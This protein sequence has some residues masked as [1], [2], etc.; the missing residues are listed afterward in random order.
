MLKRSSSVLFG[1]AVAMTAMFAGACP[2][3]AEVALEL[4]FPE[5]S[6]VTVQVEVAVDQTLTLAGQD[7]VTKQSNFAVATSNI[8][9]RAAD[10]S[11]AVV[12][13]V[14]V[15]QSELNINGTKIQF[16]SANP[17]KKADI[18]QLEPLLDIYRAVLKFPVT[19]TLDAKNQLVS[20][21]LP[22]G[23][24][25]KLGD[26]AKEKFEPESLKKESKQ[27]YAFLPDGPVKEGDTWERSA[28][29]NLGSGQVMTFRTKYEYKGTVEHDGV[30]LDKIEGKAFEVS[31]AINGNPMLQLT[32]SDLKIKESAVT[33][34]FDRERGSV[35]SRN[36]KV[37]IDGA[38]T[39]TI[40]GMELPGKVDLTMQEKGTRQK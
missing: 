32:K 25:E 31:F 30:K 12:E 16:D 20:V 34:L 28:E 5:E 22:E 21:K 2:V 17:D 40:N 10:G 6:K 26:L 38:L 27:L 33:I 23:E 9:K 4:K 29:S 14:D 13:K 15:F 24:F 37:R 36:S 11:L 39:L 18:P 19:K 3:S 7:I 1:L 8:G 35:V